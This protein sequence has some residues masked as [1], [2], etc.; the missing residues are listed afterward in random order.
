MDSNRLSQLNSGERA[1]L[2]NSINTLSSK[3]IQSVNSHATEF[4]KDAKILVEVKKEVIRIQQL[5]SLKDLKEQSESHEHRLSVKQGVEIDNVINESIINKQRGSESF[6]QEAAAHDKKILLDEEKI[7][8]ETEKN[9]DLDCLDDMFNE[10][11]ENSDGFSLSINQEMINE[12]SCCASEE[13][14]KNQQFLSAFEKSK[15]DKLAPVAQEDEI[16]YKVSEKNEG[17][18]KRPK[19]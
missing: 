5:S 17:P 7:E 16:A 18:Q 3:T 6:V 4:Q 9:I 8:L 14:S 10:F 1:A 19:G 2:Q 12:N 11:D 15:N 13:N